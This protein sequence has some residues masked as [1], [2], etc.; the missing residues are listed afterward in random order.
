VAE[1]SPVV[2]NADL[3]HPGEGGWYAE[4]EQHRRVL[5]PFPT[6]EACAEAIRNAVA[7]AGP[8]GIHAPAGAI[9]AGGTP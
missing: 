8:E 4:D 1:L 2:V 7:Q 5:G 6:K 9:G 3:M